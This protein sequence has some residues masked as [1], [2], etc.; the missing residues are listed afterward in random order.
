MFFSASPDN[1]LNVYD[2]DR[3]LGPINKYAA[4]D[5]ATRP[6]GAGV[7]GACFSPDGKAVAMALLASPFV[8]AYMWN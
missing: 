2:W 4:P 3:T 7:A 1:F 5:L 8:A 6:S